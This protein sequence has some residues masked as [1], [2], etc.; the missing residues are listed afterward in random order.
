MLPSAGES[1]ESAIEIIAKV[2]VAI[3]PNREDQRQQTPAK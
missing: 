2:A 3:R 1:I